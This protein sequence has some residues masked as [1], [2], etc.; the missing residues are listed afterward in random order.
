MDKVLGNS[1]FRTRV[2][3]G[4]DISRR[5]Y[6]AIIG[7]CLLWGFIVNVLCVNY[8]TVPYVNFLLTVP[9]GNLISIIV[10]FVVA[11]AGIVL[12]NRSDNP[13]IS[14]VGFNMV[15]LPMGI[16]I[17]PTLLAYTSLQVVYALTLTALCTALM[18]ILAVSF[19]DFFL[20]IGRGLFAALAITILVEFIAVFLF[21]AQMT[22]IDYIIALIFCGYIGFDWARAQRLPSTQD[23]AVDCACALYID[24]INLFIRILR[25]LGRSS[26]N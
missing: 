14:F 4:G 6:N 25:I 8:L 2:G 5:Q 22:I 7:A 21:H 19:P 9:F 18:M 24:I 23:N 1:I 15:V 16:M 12:V 20:S 17:I 26:N 11:I 10:Y 13:A 3:E